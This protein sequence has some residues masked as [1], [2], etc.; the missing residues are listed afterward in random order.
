MND[1]NC[2]MQINDV[3]VIVLQNNNDMMNKQNCE[4]KQQQ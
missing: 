4:Q 1:L 2:E 3:I